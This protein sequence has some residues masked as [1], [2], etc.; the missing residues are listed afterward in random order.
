MSDLKNH[1]LPDVQ[2]ALSLPNEERIYFLREE[3]WINYTLAKDILDKMDTLMKYPRKSRMPSLLLVGET[4]NGKTSIINRFLHKNSP[5]RNNEQV[6]TTKIPVIAIQAPPGGNLSELYTNI[7]N[8]FSVPF[9][10]TDK[11][12]KKQQQV[13]HYFGL[14]DLKILVIDEIHNILS[15]PVAKQTIFMNTLKTLSNDLQISIILSG[16]KDALHATNTN[17]QISNRFKPVFLTKWQLNREYLSLL[18]SIEMTLPLKKPSGIATDK[19]MAQKILDLSEGYIGEMIDLIT[20]SS[21]FAIENEIEK[22]TIEVIN[23]SGYV[24]PSL[25]KNFEDM[26]RL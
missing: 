6:E 10:N 13:E 21:E 18:A 22:I 5:T 26:V 15:G 24:K 12:A 11:I 25:R 1:V 14:C 2:K 4:N 7:L 20:V 17:S 3:K 23:K 9:K 8:Q 19:V 16:I